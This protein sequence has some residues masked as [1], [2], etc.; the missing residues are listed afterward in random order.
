MGTE[1]PVHSVVLALHPMCGH[2]HTGSIMAYYKENLYMVRF[3]KPELPTHKILDINMSTAFISIPNKIMS[4]N[5]HGLD[6]EKN[7]A[8]NEGRQGDVTGNINF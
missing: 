4:R 2:L 3:H 1:F 8:N 6:K 5:E 7:I